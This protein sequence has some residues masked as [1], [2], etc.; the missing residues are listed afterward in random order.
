ME[1]EDSFT[2]GERK[3]FLTQGA[4]N[5]WEVLPQEHGGGPCQQMQEVFKHIHGQQCP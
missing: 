4:P 1:Y 5:L 2:R 3:H